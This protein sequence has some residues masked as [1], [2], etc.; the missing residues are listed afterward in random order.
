M[1]E[2]FELNPAICRLTTYGAPSMTG[3]SNGLTKKILDA[4]GATDVVVSRSIIH[5]AN[6]YADVLAFAEVMK[7]VVQCVNCIRA[8]GLNHQQFKAFLEYLDCDYHDDV[9]WLSRA[10][11]LK[12]LWNMMMYVGS[13]ELP[14]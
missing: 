3:R 4:V 14:R 2:K 6:S 9:R 7:I 10:A 13:V 5:Q 11:T 8:R 12:R 1:A